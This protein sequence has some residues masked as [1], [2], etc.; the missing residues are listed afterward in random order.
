M[1]R[2]STAEKLVFA[3]AQGIVEGRWPPDTPLPTVLDLAKEMSISK[4]TAIK[5]V[6]LAAARGLV[7]LRPSRQALVL[8]DAVTVAGGLLGRHVAYPVAA[9]GGDGA[10]ALRPVA[11]LY[12]DI[13]WPL[14]PVALCHHL[15]LLAER[16]GLRFDLLRWPLKDQ[17]AFALS[18]PARGYAGAVCLSM[19]SLYQVGLSALRNLGFPTLIANR[20]F[21][22][23]GLPT[24][25]ADDYKPARE[26][27]LRLVSMGHRNL[28]LVADLLPTVSMETHGT[29]RGWVDGLAEGGVL[30]QCPL[31]TYIIPNL[32]QLRQS[33]RTFSE[34]LLRSDRPTALFFYWRLWPEVILKDPRF[35]QFRI[36]EDI[37][38]AVALSGE[39]AV[40]LPEAPPLT[41]L[42]LDYDR[43]ATCIIKTLIDLIDGKRCPDLLLLPL[44]LHL[45]E[46]VGPAPKR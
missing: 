33:P 21:E 43:M 5:V 7:R 22:H 41:T 1:A 29:I 15:E 19:R 16:F 20:R 26:L 4:P 39:R 14:A 32:P 44:K 17:T 18:L 13:S 34:L 42:D 31:P 46:S 40:S 3:L 10:P 11:M 6:R 9:P 12:P 27:A 45:T 28:A 2:S 37:S 30:E 35:A 24:I 38:V 36:P 23:L 8:P 25:T